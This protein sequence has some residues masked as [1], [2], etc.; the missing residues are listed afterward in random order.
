[1]N[2][3]SLNCKTILAW[4]NVCSIKEYRITYVALKREPKTINLKFQR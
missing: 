3:H 4:F 2:K 1:M